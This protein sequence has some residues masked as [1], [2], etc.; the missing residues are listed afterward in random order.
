MRRSSRVTIA[1]VM[2]GALALGAT[3]VC[4]SSTTAQQS[5]EPAGSAGRRLPLKEQLTFG[6]MART[7]SDMRFIDLVV[8]KVDEG[9][10]PRPLVDSTFLW[11]RERAARRP[12]SQ[13]PRPMIY[14]KPGLIARAKKLKIDL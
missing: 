4:V 9:V 7:K 2:V 13:A 14:F 6:L 8:E 11:A 12:A 5:T 3:F 1:G 10:L